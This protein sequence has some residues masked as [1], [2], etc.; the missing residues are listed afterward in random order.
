MNYFYR[1]ATRCVDH[2]LNHDS[3]YYHKIVPNNSY[4]L[5][6]S[7]ISVDGIFNKMEI[8][9]VVFYTQN[10]FH[11]KTKTGKVSVKDQYLKNHHRVFETKAEAI[12]FANELKQFCIKTIE[13]SIEFRKTAL[14]SMKSINP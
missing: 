8:I 5:L 14:I 3:N 9:E 13:D 1:Y 2:T 11:K 10:T 7:D 12:T 6:K 4:F